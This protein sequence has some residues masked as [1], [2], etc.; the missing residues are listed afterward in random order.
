[1]SRLVRSAGWT[2]AVVVF[3]VVAVNLVWFVAPILGS[4]DVYR[5]LFGIL[6][7]VVASAVWRQTRR[8]A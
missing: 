8:P 2:A 4:P 6:L 5:P 7:V 1:V 3:F